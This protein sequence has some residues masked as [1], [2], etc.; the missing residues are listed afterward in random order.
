MGRKQEWGKGGGSRTVVPAKVTAAPV[1]SFWRS[2]VLEGGAWMLERM[3]LV[4]DFTAEE[5]EA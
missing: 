2:I 5:M 4:Q 3:M 1:W